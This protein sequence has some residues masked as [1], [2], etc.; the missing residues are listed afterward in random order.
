[1]ACGGAGNGRG[2]G[3]IRVVRQRARRGSFITLANIP[4]V[5]GRYAFNVWQ[6][7]GPIGMEVRMLETPC[8]QEVA[9]CEDTSLEDESERTCSPDVSS[10]AFTTF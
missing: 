8:L 3:I 5:S 1:M 9:E 6:I 10:L 2:I 7:L 4:L